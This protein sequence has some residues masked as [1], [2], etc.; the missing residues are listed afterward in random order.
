M[1]D[2]SSLLTWFGTLLYFDEDRQVLR[3]GP[4]ATSPRNVVLR[5][6]AT[7]PEVLRQD[8]GPPDAARDRDGQ[9]R[10]G[11]DRD[12]L[13]GWGLH[14]DA[15]H[16][17]GPSVVAQP[18]ERR[19]GLAFGGGLLRMLPDG[20]VDAGAGVLDDWER[21]LPLDQGRLDMVLDLLCTGWYMPR[22]ALVI[23]RSE[24]A[25]LPGPRLGIGG[26]E[27]ELAAATFPLLPQT[28][29]TAGGRTVVRTLDL[30]YDGWKLERFE[31]F[32]PLVYFTIFRDAFFLESMQL[33]V[34]SLEQVGRYEGDYLLITDVS[35]E[36]GRRYFPGID[37]RRV[38]YSHDPAPALADIA[39][40][41]R[42]FDRA[43][44]GRFQPVL[45]LDA[46]I[47]ADAPIEPMLRDVMH[48]DQ[49]FFA[50]EF[51]GA[52]LHGPD[53]P[54]THWF[55]RFLE[56]Q[57]RNWDYRLARCINSGMIAARHADLMTAP[58]ATVSASWAAWRARNG[59]DHHAYLDQPFI[60]YVLQKT[61]TANVTTLD[62]YARC[63]HA[64]SPGD[65]DPRLG[66]VHFNSGVG[67]NKY[68][69][70]RAYL[71]TLLRQQEG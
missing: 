68:D 5:D 1:T 35:E 20:G 13:E 45:Y 42:L 16:G 38:H 55:G 54:A 27:A 21:L 52:D 57:D 49:I 26:F 47:V 25:L 41:R 69:R 9:D 67:H 32:A 61:R 29:G 7:Q 17:R 70:M 44:V 59:T 62:H 3:H 40:A 33:T 65:G 34:Q 14:G 51:L 15:A 43:I 6:G 31:R 23:R 12:G 58:F 71:E 36:E 8:R 19:I 11:P 22:G 28:T 37:P 24:V 48:S 66:F 10:D 4:P 30:L 53:E 50:T 39:A 60:N 46:D 64:G 18:G 63:V 2:A 56:E